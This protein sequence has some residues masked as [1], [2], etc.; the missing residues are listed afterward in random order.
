V[1]FVE[2]CWSELVLYKTFRDFHKNIGH[3]NDEII[4]NWENFQYRPWHVDRNLLTP[5]DR[6]ESDEEEEHLNP[7]KNL[8]N[9]NGR[10]YVGCIKIN[11]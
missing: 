7:Q 6:V 1:R 10:S 8:G 5:V 11:L 4:Q 2:F 9:M 3:T